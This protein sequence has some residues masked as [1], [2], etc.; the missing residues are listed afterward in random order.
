MLLSFT[1]CIIYF[2]YLSAGSSPV[3]NPDIASVFAPSDH[4]ETILPVLTNI[5]SQGTVM[6]RIEN[7]PAPNSASSDVFS[8]DVSNME[9]SNGNTNP[10]LIFDNPDSTVKS[11]LPRPDNA[12]AIG[13]RF[14]DSQNTVNNVDATSPDGGNANS[15]P[16]SIFNNPDPNSAT[17]P[18]PAGPETTFVNSG[19]NFISSSGTNTVNDSP[20]SYLGGGSVNGDTF[21]S[22][23]EAPIDLSQLGLARENFP[24]TSGMSNNNSSLNDALTTTAN[25]GTGVENLEIVRPFPFGNVQDGTQTK[26]SMNVVND[27]V[28]NS[29]KPLMRMVSKFVDMSG[30]QKP[31]MAQMGGF[32]DQP[33]EPATSPNPS[34]L[35]TVALQGIVLPGTL[36]NSGT[37]TVVNSNRNVVPVNKVP[38]VPNT[39]IGNQGFANNRS[40]GIIMDRPAGPGIQSTTPSVVPDGEHLVVDMLYPPPPFPSNTVANSNTPTDSPNVVPDFPVPTSN[41]DNAN[42]LN[43]VSNNNPNTVGNINNVPNTNVD[44]TRMKNVNVNPNTNT[45]R[46]VNRNP[47]GIVSDNIDPAVESSQRSNQSPANPANNRI[48]LRP[49]DGNQNRGSFM[50]D[51]AVQVLNTNITPNNQMTGIR[52]V[53]GQTGNRNFQSAVGTASNVNNANTNGQQNNRGQNL[54]NAPGFST[55]GNTPQ[56]NVNAGF[57]TAGRGAGSNNIQNVGLSNGA[58]GQGG[59]RSTQ[60]D[61]RS[62]LPVLQNGNLNQ[63]TNNVGLRN[64]QM[65]SRNTVSNLMP[66]QIPD[67]SDLFN[68]NNGQTNRATGVVPTNQNTLGDGTPDLP[69]GVNMQRNNGGSVVSSNFNEQPTFQSNVPNQPAGGVINTN[70]SQNRQLNPS[71]AQNVPGQNIGPVPVNTANVFSQARPVGNFQNPNSNIQPNILRQGTGQPGFPASNRNPIAANNLIP[72]QP[73]QI[74]SQQF[75]NPQLNNG[76]QVGQQVL[77]GFPNQNIPNNIKPQ[78]Q[79]NQNMDQVNTG[80][81]NT[82]ALRIPPNQQIPNQG[83]QQMVLNRA[84]GVTTGTTGQ[85]IPR[86]LPNFNNGVNPQVGTL[87]NV[88]ANAQNNAPNAIGMPRNGQ[89]FP[90][91]ARQNTVRIPNGNTQFQNLQNNQNPFTTGQNGFSNTFPNSQISS[92]E[93]GLNFGNNV[94]NN[95]VNGFPPQNNFQNNRNPMVNPQISNLRRAFQMQNPNGLQGPFMVNRNVNGLGANRFPANQA[96]QVGNFMNGPQ[97]FLNGGQPSDLFANEQFNQF[98]PN[99]LRNMPLIPFR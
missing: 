66:G 82:P 75:V 21:A 70:S 53:N 15:N 4:E 34:D 62:N 20:F 87:P 76:N 61:N 92:T 26:P 19:P 16:F 32:V 54:W 88:V 49:V 83:M 22:T 39:S 81:G 86:N 18:N 84:T 43:T 6:A 24:E 1:N 46:G 77:S 64:G 23:V 37:E 47:V 8:F 99:G 14:G 11:N 12:F 52:R 96:N 38:N 68:V 25:T 55:E 94:P 13:N 59:S 78:F 41:R 85:N 5:V 48:P 50:T 42:V 30:R 51:P 33:E 97:P 44:R 63:M 29:R 90:S 80:A 3:T 40:D 57:G 91:N 98:Q 74:G 9:P 45:Q 69:T 95:M 17:F 89:N 35:P 31:K 93:Q 56:T 60:Q 10:F 27:F 72:N 2:Q 79:N 67:G 36:T 7:T 58:N 65:E 71:A 73:N 28:D